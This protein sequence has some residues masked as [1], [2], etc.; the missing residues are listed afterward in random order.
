MPVSTHGAQ[1]ASLH[2]SRRLTVFALM[3][4][5][6]A[7]FG[8]MATPRDAHAATMKVAHNGRLF[9]QVLRDLAVEQKIRIAPQGNRVKFQRSL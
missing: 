6:V 2:R 7:S 8:A 5:L 1:R 4:A 9:P 3:A